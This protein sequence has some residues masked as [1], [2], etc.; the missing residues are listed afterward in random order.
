M[1]RRARWGLLGSYALVVLVL[2]TLNFWLPRA[3]PGQPIETLSDPRSAAFVGDAATRGALERYYGLDRPLPEQYGSYLLDLARGDL[4]TSIRRHAPV[5][6]V[7]AD[8]VGWTLLLVATALVLG[9]AIGMVA[10]IHSGWRRGRPVDRRLVALFLALDNLPSFFLAS[11]AA[12]VLAV[13]LGWFP[14]YGARTPFAQSAGPLHE[15]LD[16]AHHLA[17]PAAVLALQFVTFQYLVMRASMVGE[18]GSDHLLLGRVKGLSD[19]VLKYRYAARNALL[20]AVTV[21]T[22]HI[23]LAVTAAIFVETVFAYPGVGRLLFESVADR[24][25]P[26]MQGCF[27]VLSLAVV[28]ANLLAELLYRR[29]DPRTAA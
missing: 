8:R 21:A 5:A 29:L 26:L 23:P 17:L 11:V 18:L 12:Y 10:G 3:L 4:G 14:L 6:S 22:L 24:D 25:Y 20:P 13:R 9:T 7:L 2:V 27:L 1:R 15:I 19:R 16:V 28:A